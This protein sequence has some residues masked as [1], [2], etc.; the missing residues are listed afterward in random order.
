[1]SFCRP[2]DDRPVFFRRFRSILIWSCYTVKSHTHKASISVIWL[3][4]TGKGW[5]LCT[6]V[7]ECNLLGNFQ[8][9]R[10]AVWATCSS[11]VYSCPKIRLFPSANGR[12]SSAA[13]RCRTF[14]PFFG[15]KARQCW[16]ITR[17]KSYKKPRRCRNV[18]RG[19]RRGYSKLLDTRLSVFSAIQRVHVYDIFEIVYILQ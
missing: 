11:S 14:G 19:V 8:C 13:G 12:R 17:E 18:V 3:Y 7:D 15:S 9:W 5:R 6:A 2:H 4:V 16:G 1:M 10:Q